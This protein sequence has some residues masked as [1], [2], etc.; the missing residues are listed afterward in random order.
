MSKKLILGLALAMVLVSGLFVNAQAGCFG[1]LHW[2]S[3][4]TCQ[5]ATDRDLDRPDATCQGAFNYGP[6]VPQF[7]GNAGY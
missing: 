7:M 1:C 3:C 2:P 4:L 5:Q 6:T